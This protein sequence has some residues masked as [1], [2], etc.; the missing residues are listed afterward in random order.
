MYNDFKE[1]K[2]NSIDQHLGSSLAYLY[3]N[4]IYTDVTLVSD[5]QILSHAHKFVLSAFS[6]VFSKLIVNNPHSYPIIYLRGLHHRDLQTILVFIYLGKSD[7]SHIRA[8]EL[9][10]ILEDLHVLRLK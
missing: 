1:I 7:Y 10:R 2:W 9:T 4:N 3:R 8:A 5:D 6:Q